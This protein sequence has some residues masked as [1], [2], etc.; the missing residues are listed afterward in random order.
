[1]SREREGRTERMKD[2][3]QDGRKEGRTDG[4]KEGRKEGRTEGKGRL[5]TV[6]I[7]FVPLHEVHSARMYYTQTTNHF[8][9]IHTCKYGGL[10][11]CCTAMALCWAV[12]PP[13]GPM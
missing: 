5:S 4:R 8:V 13:W 12:M 2:G 1:M 6:Y 11:P 7:H 3:R 10:A 9:L